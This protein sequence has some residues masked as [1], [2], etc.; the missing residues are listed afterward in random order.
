MGK[1]F[2]A[3]QPSLWAFIDGLVKEQ[4]LQEMKINQ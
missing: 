1:T 2:Q 4:S 3:K